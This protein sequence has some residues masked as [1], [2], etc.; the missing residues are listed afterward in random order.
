MTVNSGFFSHANFAAHPHKGQRLAA[1]AWP[2]QN[3]EVAPDLGSYGRSS[4]ECRLSR[5]KR[6]VP[7]TAKP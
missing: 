4:E 3:P 7:T 6:E 2:C 5:V 1:S